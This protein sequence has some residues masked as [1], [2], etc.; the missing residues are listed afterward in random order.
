MDW[1]HVD[2]KPTLARGSGEEGQALSASRCGS[3]FP[4]PSGGRAGPVGA[5]KQ[6][7]EWPR[8]GGA[9]LQR[10]GHRNVQEGLARPV[11]L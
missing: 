9:E 1:E 10:W 11:G 7:L 6:G 8:Q 3:R 2:S 5:G 4:V